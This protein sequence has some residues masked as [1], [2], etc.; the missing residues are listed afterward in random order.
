MALAMFRV[1]SGSH[2]GQRLKALAWPFVIGRAETCELRLSSNQVSRLHCELRHEPNGIVVRDLCSRNG[3]FVNGSRIEEA[4]TLNEG[5]RLRIGEMELE[6]LVSPETESTVAALPAAEP[7]RPDIDPTRMTLDE[8]VH[9]E[10]EPLTLESDDA[11][12]TTTDSG[13][14][15]PGHSIGS[16]GTTIF[17]PKTLGAKPPAAPASKKPTDAD[18]TSDAARHALKKLFRGRS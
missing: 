18:F 2:A 8:L 14:P 4:T 7:T 13:Q 6:L 12:R 16:F 9:F 11:K 5:D 3:T 17:D 10:D 15:P 1:C